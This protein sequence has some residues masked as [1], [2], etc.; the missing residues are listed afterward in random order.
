M[1]YNYKSTDLTNLIVKN[2]SR[3]KEN[4]TSLSYACFIG[5]MITTTS[6]LIPHCGS[7]TSQIIGA[8]VGA[9]SF[10]L[11]KKEGEKK[12]SILDQ[13]LMD[14]VSTTL[15]TFDDLSYGEDEDEDEEPKKYLH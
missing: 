7:I 12:V 1:L 2:I 8:T 9:I 4:Y 14:S 15:L 5:G 11:V 13:T 6:I 10:Y 3:T